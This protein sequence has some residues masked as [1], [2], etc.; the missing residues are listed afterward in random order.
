MIEEGL[1]SVAFAFEKGDKNAMKRKPHDIHEEGLLSKE[2]L[3]F[4]AFVVTILGM[5]TVALY[6]Y[7]KQLGI[8]IEELRSVMFLAVSIDSLF[9]SFAFR[10]LTTP[11]WRI[12]LLS[13]LFFIGSFILSVAMLGLVV[14]VPFF[15]YLLSY[16]PLPFELVK[17]TIIAG[18]SSLVVIEL[19]KFV[20]FETRD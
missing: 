16:T 5:I 20:F 12:P 4:M 19:G 17:L 9:L 18:V 1:M 8:S 11:I 13:N 3:W 15:Q 14:S 7:V 6:L 10:S 2:M